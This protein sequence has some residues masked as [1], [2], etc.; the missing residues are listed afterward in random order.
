MAT[1]FYRRIALF[2]SAIIFCFSILYTFVLLNVQ[3]VY[4][5]KSFYFL[6]CENVHIQASTYETQLLGGA[7]Y[8]L[9]TEEQDFV[10]V[11]VYL[12]EENAALIQKQVLLPTRIIALNSC[13]LYLKNVREKRLQAQLQNAFSCLGDC[14]E[15][16]NGEIV[17]IDKGATQE[18]SKRILQT[19]CGNLFYLEKQYAET[20]PTF[21]RVFQQS[22]E[23]L[24]NVVGQII[25]AQDLRYTLCFLCDCYV[26]LGEEYSL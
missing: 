5:E 2:F 19:L 13:K 17:R 25:Y 8:L 24:E 21:S 4:V 16:L 23:Q 14:I 10:A 18:T 12:S 22:R 20:L 6:V 26:K 9:R 3:T 15:L 11:S 1:V 7:G